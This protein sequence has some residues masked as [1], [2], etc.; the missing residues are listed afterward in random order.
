MKHRTTSICVRCLERP[1]TTWTSHV[2]ALMPA[3][4][5]RRN[6]VLAGWCKP[7]AY[8]YGFRGHFQGETK[9][10]EADALERG[11]ENEGG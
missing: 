3:I 10:M 1:S 8:E 2:L 11:E 9:P 6:T 4:N 5:G 7:C